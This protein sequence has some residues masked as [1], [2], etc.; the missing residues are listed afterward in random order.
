MWLIRDGALLW[1][2]SVFFSKHHS[3]KDVSFNCLEPL[4]K[5]WR[6]T[7]ASNALNLFLSLC[8]FLQS[9][10]STHTAYIP[11]WTMR[12]IFYLCRH[13][14]FSLALKQQYITCWKVAALL[15]VSGIQCL[16]IFWNSNEVNTQRNYKFENETEYISQN[17]GCY[18]YRKLSCVEKPP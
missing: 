17:G 15:F 5:N 16:H 2:Y 9:N 6:K 10:G 18:C 8:I 4:K 12:D 13:C 3:L 14:F 1:F 11:S 7:N